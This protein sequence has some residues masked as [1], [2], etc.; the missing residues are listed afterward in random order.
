MLKQVV[1]MVIIN[2]L[3]DW[4]IIGFYSQIIYLKRQY[5]G[6]DQPQRK[7]VF[8]WLPEQ[9]LFIFLNIFNS[10]VLETMKGCVLL[11]VGA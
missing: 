3:K 11:E 2:T 7:F 5:P 8:I 4:L 6:F 10:L 9:A 1:R